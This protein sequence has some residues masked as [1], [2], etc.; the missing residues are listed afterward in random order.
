MIE[1][2]VVFDGDDIKIGDHTIKI[3]WGCQEIDIYN[4]VSVFVDTFNS[5]EQAIAYCLEQGK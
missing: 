2:K 1:A 4:G 5:L 3:H